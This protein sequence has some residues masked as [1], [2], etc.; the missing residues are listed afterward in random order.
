LQ[1]E[2]WYKL[3]ASITPKRSSLWKLL[4]TR[5]LPRIVSVF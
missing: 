1:K 5:S 3:K 4:S 2:V